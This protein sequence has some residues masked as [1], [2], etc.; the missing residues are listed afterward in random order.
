MAAT[1]SGYLR[2]GGS[3]SVLGLIKISV[4]FNLSF[5][6]DGGTNKAY[7]RATLTVQVEVVFF[8][9]SVE[10]TVETRLRRGGRSHLRRALLTPATWSEYAL[11]FA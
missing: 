3:L 4:E 1:L 10:L 7:G 8:S 5:T 2:M 11:A 6:Y 9:K